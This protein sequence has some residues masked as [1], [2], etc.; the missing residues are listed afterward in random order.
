MTLNNALLAAVIGGIIGALLIDVPAYQ[1]ELEKDPT[2][3][4]RWKL[5][6]VRVLK[7]ILSNVSVVLASYGITSAT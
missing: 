1:S 5:C 4:F 7:A 2:A 6:L 3:R